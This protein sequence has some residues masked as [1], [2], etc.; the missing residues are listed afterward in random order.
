MELKG[1]WYL[2]SNE[3]NKLSGILK[4]KDGNFPFLEIHGILYSKQSLSENFEHIICGH[5]ENGKQ[6]TLVN[7]YLNNHS[8]SS[9]GFIEYSFDVEFAIIGQEFR[10]LESILI[11]EIKI[12]PDFLIDWINLK[13]F[14]NSFDDSKKQY[15][16]EYTNPEDININVGNSLDIKF[17]FEYQ[18]PII[19]KTNYL[20]FKNSISLIFN[21]QEAIKFKDLQ[22]NI[23]KI[24]QFFSILL[25]KNL[26]NMNIKLRFKDKSL[27]WSDYYR[28]NQEKDE[29]DVN[30]SYSKNIKYFISYKEIESDFQVIILNWFDKFEKISPMVSALYVFMYM[31]DTTIE[32]KFL[33][34]VQALESFHRRT[35]HDQAAKDI[36]LSKLSSICEKLESEEEKWIREKLN[37]RYE[38]SFQERFEFIFSQ[39]ELLGLGEFFSPIS[40]PIKKIKFTRNYL[41]HYDKKLENKILSH[42]DMAYFTDRLALVLALLLLKECGISEISLSKIIQK[43]KQNKF[44]GFL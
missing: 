38:P 26:P 10:N 7:C 15:Q 19:H 12:E 28:Y 33:T 35:Q 4:I 5:A 17:K 23:F 40:E 2:P 11:N 1:I 21:F 30:K 42:S 14:R 24:Q 44:L 3:N 41:T 39:I 22:I 32:L 13:P 25:F 29:T 34:I 37:F 16:M 27:S 36:F 8:T 18:Y 31:E 6:I 43:H 20:S 9:G